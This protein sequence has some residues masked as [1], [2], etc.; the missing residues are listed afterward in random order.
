[1]S[2]LTEDLEAEFGATE[3]ILA[4]FSNGGMFVQNCE[5]R[6]PGKFKGV[7]SVNGTIDPKLPLPCP[8]AKIVVI[9][10]DEDSHA[11]LQGWS[12]AEPRAKFECWLL[13]GGNRAAESKAGP[14]SPSVR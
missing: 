7:V 12:W 2:T 11:A 10:G 1:M 14:A 5:L 9:H 3:F 4:G 13:G 6:L 8:G